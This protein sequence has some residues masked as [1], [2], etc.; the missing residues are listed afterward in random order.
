MILA[1]FIFIF[2]INFLNTKE[3]EIYL[4]FFL[5]AF[6]PQVIGHTSF[7]WA[8][9]YVSA[10]MV[11]VITLGEPIGATLLAFFI[12]GEKITALQIF[13]G[14]LILTGM[15]LAINGEKLSVSHHG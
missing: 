6:V 5:I 1:V 14:I 12:L 11:A 15:A 10:A 2:Q 8:L 9:K 7:N 13:G 3:T 4:L